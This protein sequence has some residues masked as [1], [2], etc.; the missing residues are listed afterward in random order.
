M[1]KCKFPD[2]MVIKPDG[3]NELDPCIYETVEAYANA[4]VE[5]Q[6]CKKCGHVEVV[7]HRTVDT[8]EIPKEDLDA[9]R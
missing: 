2:G 4:I 3:I 5:V 9:I 7:W 6:R 1:C 8:I